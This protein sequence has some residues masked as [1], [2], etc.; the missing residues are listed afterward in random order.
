MCE[1]ATPSTTAINM[2]SALPFYLSS[3]SVAARRGLSL[4]QA[5]DSQMI[6][7]LSTIVQRRTRVKVSGVTTPSPVPQAME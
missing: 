6:L 5:G 4:R 7:R 3:G 1:I 2:T